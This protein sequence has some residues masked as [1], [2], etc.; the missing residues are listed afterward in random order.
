MLWYQILNENA[1]EECHEIF[2][3]L[4]PGLGK[5]VHQEVLY[6]KSPEASESKYWIREVG[7]FVSF[8]PFYWN[9]QHI[10]SLLSRK[11]L[12]EGKSNTNDFKHVTKYYVSTLRLLRFLEYSKRKQILDIHKF[13]L[14]QYCY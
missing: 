1:S 7:V 3:Q 4:V 8:T 6:G 2:L 12:M 13:Y 9:K 11:E 14:L 5:G 10:F